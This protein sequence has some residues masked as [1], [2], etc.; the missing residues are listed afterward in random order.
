VTDAELHAERDRVVAAVAESPDD[1]EL[2]YDCAVAH[3]RLGLEHEAVP[4][5]VKAIGLGLPEPQ[6]RSAYLGLG[7]TYRAIGEYRK[8]L[9]V[10]DEGLGVFPD[11]EELGV[12]K[13]MT[14]Y[15]LGRAREGVS[16]LLGVIART[17]DDPGVVRYRRAIEFYA[18]HLDETW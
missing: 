4:Y 14:L 10:L 15:N 1:A 6:L 12:F 8:S 2:N 3:D 18:D 16:N 17:S 9:E 11:A 5:Y 7:S 13:A